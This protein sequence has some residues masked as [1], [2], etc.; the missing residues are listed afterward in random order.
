MPEPTKH[1]YTSTLRAIKYECS[2]PAAEVIARLNKA[3]N[4]AGADSGGPLPHLEKLR[5]QGKLEEYVAEKSGDYFL[6]F[7]DSPFH[8]RPS[9]GS[10]SPADDNKERPLVVTYTIGDPRIAQRILARNPWA[11]VC[12][13]PRLLVVEKPDRSGTSVYFHTA[14]SI[15]SMAAHEGPR[16][17]ELETILAGL[18]KKLEALVVHITAE[19]PEFGAAL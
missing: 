12:I 8:K 2:V 6:Y 11:A 1:E 5:E 17:E 19:M 14:S 10:S 7:S 15:M 16:D 9:I 3:V 13:P 18:D 4:K